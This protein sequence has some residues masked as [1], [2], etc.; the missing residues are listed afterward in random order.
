M[1]N[2]HDYQISA[3]SVT[4]MLLK[5]GKV[6]VIETIFF[7]YFQNHLLIFSKKRVYIFCLKSQI[8]S[9]IDSHQY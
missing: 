5:R 7:L 3:K 6:K 9:A 8:S 4:I 2:I 1:F